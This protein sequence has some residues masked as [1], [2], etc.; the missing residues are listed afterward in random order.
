MSTRRQDAALISVLDSVLLTG[1][2][3]GK[4]SNLPRVPF[5]IN[6]CDAYA[7]GWRPTPEEAKELGWID[8]KPPRPKDEK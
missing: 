5:A 8:G 2:D 3:P 1:D 4:V 7:L 6:P